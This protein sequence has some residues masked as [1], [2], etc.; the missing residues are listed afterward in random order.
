MTSFTSLLEET[1]QVDVMDMYISWLKHTFVVGVVCPSEGSP[2]EVS[3]Y[4][5]G[6]F[7][8]ISLERLQLLYNMWLQQWPLLFWLIWI[9]SQYSLLV[10]LGQPV[11]DNVEFVCPRIVGH[12]LNPPYMPRC[13]G[14]KIFDILNSFLPCLAYHLD[15]C[16][17]FVFTDGWAKVI[18]C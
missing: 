15:A 9:C 7:C 4:L 8:K 14:L 5:Y 12:V 16:F 6:V 17:I 1:L 2:T 10:V 13:S 11:T 18:L 3:D